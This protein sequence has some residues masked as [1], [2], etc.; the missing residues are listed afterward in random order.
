MYGNSCSALLRPPAGAQMMR[1]GRVCFQKRWGSM[2]YYGRA[3]RTTV[4]TLLVYYW[5]HSAI[6]TG[7]TVDC[8]VSRVYTAWCSVLSA[9]TSWVQGCSQ[10]LHSITICKKSPAEAPVAMEVAKHK[11]VAALRHAVFG[12]RQICQTAWVHRR[13]LFSK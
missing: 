5:I 7:V 10:A 4:G 6:F 8:T 1:G 12:H 9:G 2:R 11:E 3:V 13:G